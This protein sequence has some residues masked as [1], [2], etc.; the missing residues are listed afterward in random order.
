MA[1]FLEEVRFDL[2]S[3]ESL[4]KLERGERVCQA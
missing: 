2:D 1:D 4:R 3:R